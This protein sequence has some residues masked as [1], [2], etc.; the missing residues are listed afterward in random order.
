MASSS[1]GSLHFL[2]PLLCTS[3]K[4]FSKTVHT[5]NRRAWENIRACL[6]TPGASEPM[7]NPRHHNSGHQ[8]TYVHAQGLRTKSVSTFIVLQRCVWL[9]RTPGRLASLSSGP[10]MRRK[11]SVREEEGLSPSMITKQ[12]CHT[13]QQ[14]R[15][16]RGGLSQG[17]E[18]PRLW[19]LQMPGLHQETG[20]EGV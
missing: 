9:E 19:T 20:A 8:N 5:Q 7:C 3:L 4:E 2:P 1:L 13:R 10:V 15:H 18:P 14:E 17:D 12:S 11:R 6:H 16:M